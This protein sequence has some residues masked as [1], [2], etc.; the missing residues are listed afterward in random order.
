M[1]YRSTP[2]G[3]T[4]VR[5]LDVGMMRYPTGP[6]PGVMWE[7]EDELGNRGW[8]SSNLFGLAR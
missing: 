8:V 5:S 3:K 7:V 2:G 6:T 4:A 1:D